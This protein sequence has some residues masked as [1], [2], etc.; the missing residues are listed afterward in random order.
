[1]PVSSGV[2]ARGHI[3]GL[4]TWA[5]PTWQIASSKPA[6]ERVG[7]QEGSQNVKYSILRSDIPSFLLYSVG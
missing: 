2:G 7:E 1:M 4:V 3:Q 6:R 5:S